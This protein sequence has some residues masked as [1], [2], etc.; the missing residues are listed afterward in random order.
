MKNL[1]RYVAAYKQMDDEAKR[2][3]L[4]IAE[5]YAKEWPAPSARPKLQLVPKSVSSRTF[6]GPLSGSHDCDATTVR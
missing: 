2:L 5:D 4:D 6:S 3:I 1:E